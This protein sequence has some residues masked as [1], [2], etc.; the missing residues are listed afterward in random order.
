MN[1]SEL[2]ECIASKTCIDKNDIIE[3]FKATE[4]IIFD[5]LSNVQRNEIRKVF[6]M[7]GLFAE[8]KIIRKKERKIPKGNIVKGRD[9]ISISAK[10]SRRYR[11]KINQSR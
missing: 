10:I 3:I 5:Y 6:I 7:N 9:Y 8:S 1:K 2:Y 4:D 11:E